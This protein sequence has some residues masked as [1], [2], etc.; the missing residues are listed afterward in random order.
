MTSLFSRGM[1]PQ[2]FPS[3]IDLEGLDKGEQRTIAMLMASLDDDWIVA[4]HIE[5]CKD[6]QD[7]EIDIL[8]ISRTSGVLCMEVKG[9]VISYKSGKWWS[10]DRPARKDPVRQGRLAKFALIDRMKASGVDLDGLFIQHV[11]GFPDIADFPDEG[12][13][14]DCPREVIFTRSELEDPQPALA[15]L[16]HRSAHGPIPGERFALFLKALRPDVAEVDVTGSS[17]RAVWQRADRATKT[18]LDVVAGLDENR[19]VL[20]HGGAGTGKTVL[21][22]KWVRR[23]LNRGEDTLFLC[24]N[25]ILGQELFKDR[26]SLLDG[27]NSEVRYEV[28]SFH[29]LLRQMMKDEA[30][31][32]PANADSTFWDGDFRR[33]FEESIDK[34]EGRFDTLVIDEGQDMKPEWL[35]SLSLLLKDTNESKILM[36]ADS[37]Q[38][39]YTEGWLA[40]REWASLKL[41]TNLRNPRT[42][43]RA[44]ES[45]GGAPARGN[46]LPGPKIDFHRAGGVKEVRKRVTDAIHK[47]Q[48]DLQIPL[49]RI[50]VLTRHTDL[51]DALRGDAI[52]REGRDAVRLTAWN[53]RDEGGVICETIHA[54]KGL[55]RE[56]V[57]LVNIDE[58]PDE[59]TTYIGASRAVLYLA[60]VGQEALRK[61]LKLGSS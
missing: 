56:A 15:K 19:R 43:A 31:V 55:E 4:P 12:A 49:S 33:A 53:D 23:S 1:P 3:D 29:A 27:I 13:G 45:L 60:V 18:M 20:V 39:I 17:I 6:G 16:R 59:A 38:A 61:Q 42:I 30:P 10:Y 36:V 46:A 54:T 41:T 21:A 37:R 34:I 40:P 28:G 9:G 35:G 57:I 7:H 47:A 25:R 22:K 48:T 11:V 50:L 51:R 5:V 52:E 14:P 8:L 2:L 26:D 24:F 44:V 32:V 58:E